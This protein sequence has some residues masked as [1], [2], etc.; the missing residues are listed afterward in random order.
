[1]EQLMTDTELNQLISRSDDE[2]K[3]FEKMDQDRYIIDQKQAKEKVIEETLKKRGKELELQ[4]SS[5]NYRLIQEWEV[6]DFVKI[7]KAEEDLNSDS[8]IPAKRK[9]KEANYKDDLD[10]F[11]LNSMMLPS[12]GSG[13]KQITQQ[14][15]EGEEE[16]DEGDD[17]VEKRQMVDSHEIIIPIPA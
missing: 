17:V 7:K 3:M 8:L 6:P 5:I 14:Q 9:K 10:D 15:L 16:M 13:K 2:L 1:M 12:G 4:V 11:T